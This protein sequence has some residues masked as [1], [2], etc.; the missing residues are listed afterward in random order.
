MIRTK[1]RVIASIPIMMITVFPSMSL[2]AGG[3][4]SPSS[5]KASKK[6]SSSY[7]K[8]AM[9]R[10]G[11]AKTLINQ[12]KYSTAYLELVSLPF[13]SKDEADR[14]NLLGFTARKDDQL[15]TAS[16]HYKNA[17]NI[18]SNHRGALE[19]QGELFLML[20]Q[21]DEAR[22]NLQILKTLCWIGCL[23]ATKLE[24]AISKY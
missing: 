15:E 17:L 19:Y 1:H 13:K 11:D 21:I 9:G 7:S 24:A 3:E 22:K 18:D 6:N 2:S 8:A 5:N 10:F 16:V 23:E 12:K 14:Q 4:T 20:G